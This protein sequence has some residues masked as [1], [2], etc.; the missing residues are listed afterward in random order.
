M[1]AARVEASGHPDGQLQIEVVDGETGQ[2]LAARIH[3]TDVRGRPV[4]LALPGSAPFADH[5]YING[6]VTLPLRVGQYK[7]ELETGP[8]YRTRSGHFEIQRHADDTERIEMHGFA[9]LADEGWW[10]GDLDVPRSVAGRELVMRAEALSYVPAA[11][12]EYADGR[13]RDALDA[14]GKKG[15]AD[16]GGAGLL[17]FDLEKPLDVSS[18]MSPLAAIRAARAAGG[19]IVARMPFAWDLPVW[20]ASGELDA[21]E[22]IHHHAL[23]KGVADNEAGGR[24]TRSRAVPR[25]PRQR[26]LERNDL[27]PHARLRAADPAGRRQRLGRERQ[28]ARHKSR[29]RRLRHEFSPARWWEGLDAGRVFVTNGPLLRPLVEGQPPGYVFSLDEHEKLSLEI[30][31]RLATRAPI[32]YLEIIKDGQIEEE[33]RL[34]DWAK[35]KGRLPPLEF[36]SSGWFLV[37]AVT[38]EPQKYE[39]ASTGPYYVER[40]GRPRISRTSVEFFLDWIDEWVAQIEPARRPGRRGP[41]RTA[42]RPRVCPQFLS[43]SAGKSHCRLSFRVSGPSSAQNPAPFVPKTEKSRLPLPALF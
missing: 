1:I 28:S 33:I 2:P 3:L 17:A 23:R 42:S 21:I 11:E 8:E 41:G 39:F 26:P 40:G 19:H 35:S 15:T 31:L 30:G 34:A 12:W 20:L 43:R 10:A 7:F 13:W 24:T 22:L 37:R 6:H 14:T 36:D 25:P 18:T 5:F 4:K 29:V 38:N 16:A 9:N 27:L 32:D